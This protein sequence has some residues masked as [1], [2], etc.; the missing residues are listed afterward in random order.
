MSEDLDVNLILYKLNKYQTKLAHGGGE[1]LDTYRQKI[2][3]Y[4]DKRI[5]NKL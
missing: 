4:Y 2:Q 5:E 1:N 3:F